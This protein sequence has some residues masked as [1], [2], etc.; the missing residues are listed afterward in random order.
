MV[1]MPASQTPSRMRLAMIA[2]RLSRKNGAEP[3]IP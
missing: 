1:R 2:S 3:T